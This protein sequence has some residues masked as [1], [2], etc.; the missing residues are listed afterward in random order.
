MELAATLDALT[1]WI[2]R[3]TVH[4][5]KTPNAYL[6]VEIP[7][8]VYATKNVRLKHEDEIKEKAGPRA[9]C[10]YRFSLIGLRDK[11]ETRV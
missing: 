4:K 7:D 3:K 9:Q 6:H 2:P 10:T 1:K 5:T 11:K 8:W